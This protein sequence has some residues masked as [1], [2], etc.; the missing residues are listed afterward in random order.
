MSQVLFGDLLEL[1]L[2]NG[3]S[4]PSNRRGSGTQMINMREIF[5]YD[6]IAEQKCELAP[7]TAGEMEHSLL[8]AGDLLF[9]R[10]SLTYEGAGKCAIFLG[11]SDTRSWESHIIRARLNKKVASPG[12]YYYYFRSRV[13]RLSIQT[14]VQQVAAAGIRGSDLK[15]LPVP[16]PPIA[17][18]R[19]IA[20][21]LG[22]LDDKIAANASTSA[23]AESLLRGHF[24]KLGL[25]DLLGTAEA[26]PLSALI[27]FNPPNP[28]VTGEN[29][30]YLD[31]QNL[32]T[33]SMLASRWGQ[34][35]AR[36]GAR[37]QNG[38]T[39]LARI[40]PCLENRKTG[41]VDFLSDGAVAIGST[42]FVVMRTRV[43]HHP[44]LS[45]FIA[46]DEAF[47]S[48]AIQQMIGTSGRQR[49]SARDLVD[50]PIF[51]HADLSAFD[52]LAEKIVPLLGSL[53]DESNVLAT[54]RDTLL[55]ELMSGRLRVKD[56][57]KQ[58]EDVL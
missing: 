42:E 34:R 45:F 8:T 31:M 41:F 44:S 18:Q 27:D 40:T 9:A 17:E 36:G 55:P 52:A 32:P 54:L 13:G 43:G 23:T 24:D 53:R 35:S 6:R 7:L 51:A 29:P 48:F 33:S 56:A 57:E 16:K 50:Y 38:D 21:V 3:I 11:A 14:I 39:L 12:F 4:C 37:F 2:R 19:A 22:A 10:Q 28:T 26:S 58:V 46:T 1:P 47:R 20:E 25:I 15:L 30:V 5:A 49:V